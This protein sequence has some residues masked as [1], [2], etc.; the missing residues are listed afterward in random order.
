MGASLPPFELRAEVLERE[1]RQADPPRRQVLRWWWNRNH[2]LIDRIWF[3][4]DIKGGEKLTCLAIGFFVEGM[5]MVTEPITLRPI[6]FATG[7]TDDAVQLQIHALDRADKLTPHKVRRGMWRFEFPELGGALGLRAD[8]TQR[9]HRKIRTMSPELFG[10]LFAEKIGD[11]P[12]K[13]G[14][15]RRG[16]KGDRARAGSASSGVPNG[17]DLADDALTPKRLAAMEDLGR[18]LHW[19]NEEFPRWNRRPGGEPLPKILRAHDVESQSILELLTR[20]Y[21]LDDVK[22]ASVILWRLEPTDRWAKRIVATDRSCHILR[23][24]IT[25]L[26]RREPPSGQAGSAPTSTGEQT[27]SI[28][29]RRRREI[30]RCIEGLERCAERLQQRPDVAAL[31]SACAEAAAELRSGVFDLLSIDARLLDVARTVFDTGALEEHAHR[32]LAA[33]RGRLGAD[34][35]DRAVRAEVERQLRELSRV[36]NLARLAAYLEDVAE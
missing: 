19:H 33:S 28:V 1:Y 4:Q 5:A 7:L 23:D 6:M 14:E 3:D 30:N 15:R 36:P 34:D 18:Y 26:L 12:E 20:G 24:Y 32:D 2:Y 17:N 13:F 10:E 25:E 29:E 27:D 21:S 9:S 16:G 35:Y 31:G 22:I 8:L 11:Q